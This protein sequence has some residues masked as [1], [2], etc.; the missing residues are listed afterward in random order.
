LK[1]TGGFLQ[2]REEEWAMFMPLELILVNGMMMTLL[3]A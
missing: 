2:R 3:Q 1:V